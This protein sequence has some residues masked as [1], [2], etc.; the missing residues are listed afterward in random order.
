MSSVIATSFTWPLLSPSETQ[1]QTPHTIVLGI[2]YSA[3][4]LA[5]GAIATAT[6]QA[7]KLAR[8]ATYPDCRARVCAMLGNSNKRP[9][10]VQLFVWQ[11]PVM[12]QNGSV[13]L[14]IGGLG[15]LIWTTVVAEDLK[16]RVE[17]F[18][19]QS[20][21]IRGMYRANALGV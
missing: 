1:S 9:R 4:L 14:F 5:L 8:L 10:A 11:S 15:G 6:Q 2:W 20:D 19:Y 12:L 18:L 16:V 7:I 13:Y 17:P 21:A 3:L